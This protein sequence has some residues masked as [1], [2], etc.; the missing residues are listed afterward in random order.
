MPELNVRP[1]GRARA[2]RAW[3]EED[4]RLVLDPPLEI[5]PK[6]KITL[7]RMTEACACV[8]VDVDRVLAG[9]EVELPEV[10]PAATASRFLELALENAD[11]YDIHAMQWVRA[12]ALL[13]A[14]L[15]HFIDASESA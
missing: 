10:P 6:S 2:D 15:A 14:A 9:K 8:G 13:A 1:S 12:K 11:A 4:G 3:K 7:E 5:V